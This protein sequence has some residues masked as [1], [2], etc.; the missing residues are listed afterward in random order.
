MR[1]VK[2]KGVDAKTKRMAKKAAA[3]L[4]SP[5]GQSALDQILKDSKEEADRMREAQRMTPADWQAEITI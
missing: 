5:E 1:S 2:L 4:S 3:W